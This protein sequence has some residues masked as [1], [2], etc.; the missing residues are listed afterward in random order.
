MNELRNALDNVL[1][2]A[3]Q[4]REAQATHAAYERLD[5]F[6]ADVTTSRRSRSQGRRA[7]AAAVWR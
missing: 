6:M 5:R 7:A 1:A 2:H 3:A 4:I